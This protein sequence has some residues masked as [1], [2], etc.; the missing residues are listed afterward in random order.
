MS[1]AFQTVLDLSSR[2]LLAL[3][4]VAG[5]ICLVDW[6]IRARRISPFSPIARFFRRWID[7]LLKPMETIIVRRGGQ[8]QQAPFYAFMAVIV[9]GIALLYLLRFFGALYVQARVGVTSPGRFGWMLVGW[10]LDFL[11]LA[12]I[13]RVVSSW[14]PVSPYSK[15]IRWSYVST[16]WF[17]GPLRRI[18]PP[19]GQIDLSPLVAYVLLRIVG[20]ILRV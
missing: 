16:E 12:L 13:V 10:A 2:I 9:G 19:W 18:I 7:P 6:A 3:A 11:V 5:I 1:P 14:L 17:M 4:V 15:W 8:P 20:G